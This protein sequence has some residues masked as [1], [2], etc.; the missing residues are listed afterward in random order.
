MGTQTGCHRAVLQDIRELMRHDWYPLGP[1]YGELIGTLCEPFSAVRPLLGSC[2]KDP[3]SSWTSITGT[4]TC[5]N[6][7]ALPYGN[8]LCFA[9]PS[10]WLY[11]TEALN[12]QHPPILISTAVSPTEETFFFFRL[13]FR[14]QTLELLTTDQIYASA[15]TGLSRYISTFPSLYFAVKRA[16]A[17]SRHLSCRGSNLMG[18]KPVSP[19]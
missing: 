3:R 13:F 10:T 18:L 14:H 12:C 6:V 5:N 1:S 8:H 17:T 19:Y 15:L 11:R 4:V 7:I 16:R 9:E 2:L